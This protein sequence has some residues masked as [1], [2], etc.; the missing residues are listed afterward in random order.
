MY[1]CVPAVFEE[2]IFGLDDAIETIF[3]VAH[4]P[5]ISD[6]AAS[7]SSGKVQHMPT[8]AVVGIE[9]D[10]TRWIDMPQAGKT[11]FLNDTPKRQS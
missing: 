9:L 8:C 4:N 10:A 3:I 11:L 7:L 1:H 6:F 2:I 5:G